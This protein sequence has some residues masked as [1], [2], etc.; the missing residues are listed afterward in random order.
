MWWPAVGVLLLLA[1]GHQQAFASERDNKYAYSEA[2]TLWVNKVGPYNNP[3]E[4]YNYFYLPYCKAKPQLKDERRW[5]GLGEVLQGNELINSHIDIKF[6]GTGAQI[7][8]PR[9]R[10]GLP[11][12]FTCM[13]C[14]GLLTP[15]TNLAL[16][17]AW[18]AWLQCLC[19]KRRSAGRS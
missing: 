6:K 14:L 12:L 2:V 19:L 10:R 18:L 11:C 1:A 3:T 8:H 7:N 5:G 9:C 13:S 4:T 17:P 15:T 16:W